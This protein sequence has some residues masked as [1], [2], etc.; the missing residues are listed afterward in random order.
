MAVAGPMEIPAIVMAGTSPSVN[1]FLAGPTAPGG[2]DDFP[3]DKSYHSA[4]MRIFIV[5]AGEVGFHIASS[6]SREGHDLVII[7]GDREKVHRLEKSLDVLAVHGDA[8]NPQILRSQGIE[9]ADLFFAVTNDDPVN[10]L[11]AITARRLGA[12]RSV[13]RLGNVFHQFNPLLQDDPDLVPLYPEQLVAEEIL[14]L[15]KVPGAIKAHFFGQGRLVLLHAKPSLDAAIYDQQLK[16]M[17]GPDGWVLTGIRRGGE[18]LIPRGDTTLQAGDVLYAVGRTENVPAFLKSVGVESRPVRRVLIAGGGQV[19]RALARLLVAERIKVTVIQ[20]SQ[21]R[22]SQVA[23]Q[24][25]EALVLKGDA[26]DPDIL[27]EAGVDEVDYFVAATQSDENNIFA[28][29]LA[30]ELGAGSTIVLY[31]KHEFKN[32]LQ[33][34]QLGVPLSP[35]L[36]IA[37]TILRM[38]HGREILSLDLMEEGDAEAVEFEV[39]KE[40]RVLERPLKDLRFPRTAIVGA[41]MR[42]DDLFVPVGD[43]TFREGDRA[44]VFTLSEALPALEKMFSYR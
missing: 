39:P 27:R 6:L 12:S 42:G 23:S 13:V 4:P 16:Y 17:N 33:T 21:E 1:L 36:V 30:R 24:V 29:L 28:A 41:V 5:G 14:G 40:A 25:P 26:T 35:R 37:G 15:T 38:V 2:V 34:V 7:E 8:C 32:V 22:A 18:L 44:L 19:G 3:G 9:N 10:L 31:Q 43:F 11:S 20:R